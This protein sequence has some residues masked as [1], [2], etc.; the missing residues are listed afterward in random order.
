MIDISKG[1][2]LLSSLSTSAG[3]IFEH[4]KII[5]GAASVKPTTSTGKSA[6]TRVATNVGTTAKEVKLVAG[7][8]VTEITVIPV[9]RSGSTTTVA[10]YALVCFDVAQAGV[11]ALIGADGT[12]T[13]PESLDSNQNSYLVPV[14]VPIT[15]QLA[16]ALSYDGTTYEG[17]IWVRSIDN[18]NTLDIWL[19]AS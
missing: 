17:N 14:N 15:V 19:G 16:N 13:I 3:Q 18:T 9:F 12:T 4:W 10:Q 5:G 7:D 11:A 2:K 6:K 8:D 1:I